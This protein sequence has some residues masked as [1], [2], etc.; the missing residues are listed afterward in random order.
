M[1]G[2]CV[3][4]LTV[5][6]SFAKLSSNVG[7]C[8]SLRAYERNDGSDT[9]ASDFIR[10]RLSAVGDVD[11]D[12]DNEDEEEDDGSLTVVEDEFVDDEVEVAG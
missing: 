2:I 5:C 4:L 1:S 7:D 12:A 8:N 10:R 6:N 3:A 9:A 11:D